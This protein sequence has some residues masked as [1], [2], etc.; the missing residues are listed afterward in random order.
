MPTATP[1]FVFSMVPMQRT[2]FKTFYE[3]GP[4]K[5]LLEQPGNLRYAGWDLTSSGAATLVKGEYLEVKAGERKVFRLYEDG[6]FVARVSAGEDFLSWGQ[7]QQGFQQNPRLNPLAII[8]FTFNFVRFCAQLLEYL[9]PR[10]TSFSF[11][12]E[13]RN[14][15]IDGTRLYLVPYGVASHAFVFGGER[16]N[17]PA[18]HMRKHLEVNASD[19]VGAPHAVAFLLVQKIYSWFGITSEK[20]PYVS[21]MGEVKCVDENAIKTARSY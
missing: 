13:L 16:Y 2:A 11:Q 10:P 12:I 3:S 21:Q 5:T 6:S 18:E 14:A 20:I 17:A 9:S 15:F 19:L 1:F 7:N 4:L 8:E